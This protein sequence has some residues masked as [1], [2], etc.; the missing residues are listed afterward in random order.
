M[1]IYEP[2][3]ATPELDA[4]ESPGPMSSPS[5]TPTPTP[6]Y[7]DPDAPILC[8]DDSDWLQVDA[9]QAILAD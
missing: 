1:S 4:G 9:S 3:P 8:S 5:P 2:D 6:I 7:C